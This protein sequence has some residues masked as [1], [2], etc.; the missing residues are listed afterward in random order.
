MSPTFVMDKNRTLIVGTPGG[1]R[2]ISMVML[3]SIY[4]MMDDM[5][6]EQWVNTP[7]FHHQFL[8]DVVQ[9]EAGAF[10]PAMI[11]GLQKRGHHLKKMNRQYGN[12]QAILW[13]RS[14]HTL[15]GISDARGEGNALKIQR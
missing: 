9:Y 4:F 13:N 14:T 7:R 10:S 5:P 12:M 8:P 6:P 2:I 1:S 3:A 11:E 15:T